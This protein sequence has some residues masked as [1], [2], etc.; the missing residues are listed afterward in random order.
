MFVQV[1]Q[2]LTIAHQEGFF[3]KKG[4]IRRRDELELVVGFVSQHKSERHVPTTHLNLNQQQSIRI[5]VF[6]KLFVLVISKNLP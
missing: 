2:V 5:N 6:G 1:I 3:K 4:V